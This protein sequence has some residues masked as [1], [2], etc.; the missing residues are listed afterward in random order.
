MVLIASVVFAYIFTFWCGSA[1]IMKSSIRYKPGLAIKIIGIFDRERTQ[2]IDPMP[3]KHVQFTE[4]FREHRD[5][6]P[7]QKGSKY[8]Y[9]YCIINVTLSV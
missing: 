1:F 9:I 3:S 6:T 5:R 7:R 8:S 4:Q 2:R